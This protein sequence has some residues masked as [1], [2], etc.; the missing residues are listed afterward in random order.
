[1]KTTK[2]TVLDYDINWK[3]D[4]LKIKNEL[5]QALKNLALSIEH[6]GST[7][8]EGLAAK[9]IIDIDIVIASTSNLN[10]VIEKL[11]QIGC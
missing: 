2:V 3:N 4:F 6:V 9:P 10:K 7:A 5:D 11:N 1:M 8:V